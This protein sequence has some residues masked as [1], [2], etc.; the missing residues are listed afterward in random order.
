MSL[1]DVGLI[2]TLTTHIELL[3][4]TS[5]DFSRIMSILLEANVS[6]FQ[7]ENIIDDQVN[8][9]TDYFGVVKCVIIDSD[10]QMSALSVAIE[11]NFNICYYDS[12]FI[13]YLFEFVI[14]Y[15]VC[16]LSDSV[17]STNLIYILNTSSS[18]INNT[19]LD[20]TVIITI[21]DLYV[22][23]TEWFVENLEREFVL[24]DNTSFGLETTGSESLH[25]SEYNIKYASICQSNQ[26]EE[27][28]SINIAI[29][30]FKY[31]TI[32]DDE[33]ISAINTMFTTLY[34]DT[35]SVIF[36]S[37]QDVDTTVQIIAINGDEKA[38]N[39]DQVLYSVN[40]D[41]NS[42]NIIDFI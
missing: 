14:D 42:P 12:N 13:T 10:D 38:S 41:A 24:V 33:L 18:D 37:K 2:V 1:Y 40:D 19:I 35:I 16:V 32:Y 17:T 39:D 15:I 23:Q 26:I 4:Y 30:N 8:L 3:L 36:L 28:I 22:T 25:D 20:Y 34:Q 31:L 9:I 21:D 11:V 27:V 29:K 5:N 6:I 7:P